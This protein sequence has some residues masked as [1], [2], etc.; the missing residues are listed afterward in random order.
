[1]LQE[2]SCVW[3]KKEILRAL[4]WLV[5]P[6]TI[7]L[8]FNTTYTIS[9]SFRES[10]LVGDQTQYL[11]TDICKGEEFRDNDQHLLLECFGCISHC[12]HTYNWLP[13][14]PANLSKWKAKVLSCQHNAFYCVLQ[15]SP[16][17]NSKYCNNALV[18][19]LDES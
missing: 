15:N 3:E 6:E 1:M 19:H 14:W 5:L 18:W 8:V 7:N 13:N 12:A 17:S 4:V 11:I 9:F 10:S 16:I 2:Q